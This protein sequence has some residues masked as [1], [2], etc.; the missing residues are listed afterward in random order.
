MN[1]NILDT[2]ENVEI[3]F[4]RHDTKMTLS[5]GKI[6][7]NIDTLHPYGTR[8]LVD[9]RADHADGGRFAGTIGT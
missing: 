1:E 9:E 6:S 8:S 7:I 3:K 5:P 4:L 2:L